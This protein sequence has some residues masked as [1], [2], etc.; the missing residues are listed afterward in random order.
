[1]WVA[2]LGYE[3][4]GR[5]FESSQGAPFLCF[6]P[7]KDQVEGLSVFRIKTYAVCGAVRKHDPQQFALFVWVLPKVQRIGPV[8][9]F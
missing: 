5:E 6:G 2:E 1:M 4:E 3:P 9:E 7:F 8:G